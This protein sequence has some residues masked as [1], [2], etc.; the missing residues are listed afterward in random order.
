MALRCPN[1]GCAMSRRRDEACCPRCWAQLPPHVQAP[2]RAALLFWREHHDT[3][4]RETAKIVMQRAVAS[5]RRIWGGESVPRVFHFELWRHSGKRNSEWGWLLTT[6]S[7]EA[8]RATF[9][10]VK[11]N[12][13]MGAVVLADQ[14]G[15]VLLRHN[16]MGNV[17][18]WDKRM[19]KI[20]GVPA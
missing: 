18:E 5:A 2:L 13:D 6:P 4:R 19:A 8:A 7:E 17:V 10:E 14:D 1:I 15:R 12:L 11:R 16:G 20:G 9:R 3:S